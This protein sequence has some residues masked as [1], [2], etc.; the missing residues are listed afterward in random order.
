[1]RYSNDSLHLLAAVASVQIQYYNCA[2]PFYFQHKTR[3]PFGREK[4]VV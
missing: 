1:M 3:Q 4:D 2:F